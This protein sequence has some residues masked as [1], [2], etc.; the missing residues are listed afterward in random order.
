MGEGTIFNEKGMSGH[1][2]WSSIKHK[3]AATDAKRAKVFTRVAKDITIAA[4]SGGGD[5]E[6]NA[7][8]KMAIEKAR[9]ANMPKD[10]I[11][12]AIKRGTGEGSEGARIEEVLYEAMGPGGSAML[13]LCAT[14]NTNRALTE[15][16]TVLKKNG[17]KFVSGGGVAFQFAHVGQIA[18]ETDDVESV[19]LAAIDA[20]AEDVVVNDGTVIITT[21]VQDLHSVRSALESAGIVVADARIAYVPTQEIT[22]AG[23]DAQAYEALYD[24]VEELDDV[25]EV[26]TNVA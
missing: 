9:A 15:V 4:Q 2:K 20:G 8:L 12:R 22:L 7:S 11:E 5:P 1:N 17:G 21:S 3:K 14:D 23:A 19:E 6:M 13:I 16:K 10:N 26:F 18:V 24:L 25:Q